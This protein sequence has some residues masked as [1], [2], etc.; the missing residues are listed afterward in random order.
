MNVRDQARDADSL[1]SRVRTL[2][3]RY[4]EAPELAWGRTEVFDADD[5]GVLAHLAS[6][7]EGAVLAL[8][9][10]SARQTRATTTVPGLEGGRTLTDAFTGDT[11]EAAAGGRVG[12][13][14]APYGYRWLRV[15]TPLD[16]PE[17]TTRV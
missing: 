9:N 15:D 5:P 6:L 13:G 16:D 1:L 17:R 4:R 7:P 11:V 10:L 3:E 8:H 14:L 12:V 2:I